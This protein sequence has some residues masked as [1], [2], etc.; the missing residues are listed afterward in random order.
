LVST[1]LK[2]KILVISSTFPRWKNDH[3]PTF[4][5]ELS[6]RLAEKYD[7]YVLAPHTAGAQDDEIFGNIL[8]HRFKYGPERVEKLAYNGGIANNLKLQPLKY[9][10]I[11]PFLIAEYFAARK[12]VTKYQIDLVHAHWLIPQG[13]I[14]VLLK[15]LAGHKV[16]TL[17][18]AHGSDI[19]S[20]NGYITR[21]IKK[22]I[23]SNCGSL[24]VVSNSMKTA[25]IEMGCTCQVNVLPMGTD[26]SR[27]FVP[28]EKKQQSNKV[29]F[30]GRLIVQK[31]VNFLLESF[32]DVVEV[33]P[34]ATLQIIGHGPE[35]VPLKKLA[36]NLGI[37]KN[38][39]FVGG[40][41]YNDIA[42]YLQSSPV[43][44]FPYCRN[45]Q[46]GEEGFG[47]VIIEALGCGCAVIASRQT[48][49]ME[50]IKD[51][52]TGL[53][54]NEGDPAGISQAILKLLNQPALRKSLAD[55]GRAEVLEQ[56]N[57]VKISQSYTALIESCLN[58]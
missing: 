37:E 45:E 14:A 9:L 46:G 22:Y 3:E 51:K 42:T 11:L 44:V 28:N 13:L 31:G 47:L 16:K 30:V 52:Q 29:I 34:D 54:I 6:K 39:R 50:I 56:F 1:S 36:K 27:K 25:V 24:T 18:T 2:K 15:R 20:Y 19:F 40:I 41:P 12:L 49:I 4:V 58:D 38:V 33:Y 7:V 55:T 23:L 21:K 10:L 26:L 8:V 53:L 32:Y 48:A 43:A 5:Y 35:F 17:V 57:W